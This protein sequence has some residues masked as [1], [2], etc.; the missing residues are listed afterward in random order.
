[1]KCRVLE[2]DDVGSEYGWG[3]DGSIVCYR[4]SVC[5]FLMAAKWPNRNVASGGYV[6]RGK[7]IALVWNCRPGNG[8]N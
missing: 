3:A 7:P 4:S 2:P 6:S 5:I 8:K 1:M